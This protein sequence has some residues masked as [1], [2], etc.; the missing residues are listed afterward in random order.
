MFI[1]S[2]GTTSNYYMYS[3]LVI[4]DGAYTQVSFNADGS[5][6]LNT[7]ISGNVFSNANSNDFDELIQIIG[8]N[9][10]QRVTY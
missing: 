10:F 4:K 6:R 1:Y 7:K 5:F 2:N 9:G 3:N 8:N